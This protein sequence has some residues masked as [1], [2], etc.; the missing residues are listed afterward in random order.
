PRKPDPPSDGDD[1]MATGPVF[2]RVHAMVLCD[3]LE[4]TPG[5]DPVFNLFGVRTL[6]K[7]DSFPY[8]HPHLCVYMQ[9][10]GHAGTAECHVVAVH[11]ENDSALLSTP[12]RQVQF[13]GPLT[14]V[15]VWW[16]IGRCSFPGPGLYYFQV[17]FGHRLACERL[18]V[19][20]AR[21]VLSNGEEP[22]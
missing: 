11:A 9:A 18:L 5:E 7:A 19:V 15:P 16:K 21:E 13:L 22:A 4:I 10:T 20:S 3:D 2:P 8:S 12:G 14:I 6:I 17:Y 1:A